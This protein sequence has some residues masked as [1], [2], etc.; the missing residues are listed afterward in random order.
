MD[1][2]VQLEVPTNILTL[3]DS[4]FQTNLSVLVGEW[5]SRGQWPPS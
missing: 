3:D 5:T 1:K 4:L 2:Y